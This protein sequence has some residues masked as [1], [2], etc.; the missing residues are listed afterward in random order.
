M[1]ID[2]VEL[3]EVIEN[4]KATLFSKREAYGNAFNDA[5]KILECLYPDGVSVD[6]YS[7][8]LSIVRIL[9][10]LH[11]ISNGADTEDPWQDIAGYAVLA[12]EKKFVIKQEDTL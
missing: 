5:P 6:Q 3:N 1:S 9:D 4:L 11:R 10:K 8:L 12:M 7:D 2:Y